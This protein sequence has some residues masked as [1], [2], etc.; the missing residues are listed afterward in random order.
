MT[1]NHFQAVCQI[2]RVGTE[3]MDFH[4]NSLLRLHFWIEEN[5][6]YGSPWCDVEVDERE[7]EH[8]PSRTCTLESCLVKGNKSTQ[9]KGSIEYLIQ[10]V[11]YRLHLMFVICSH[12]E[13]IVE[14]CNAMLLLC[15][16]R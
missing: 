13:C 7:S 14:N 1:E 5:K 10:F 2:Q 11:I 12:V 9:A 6:I 16:I 15:M 3:Y 4:Q 8:T